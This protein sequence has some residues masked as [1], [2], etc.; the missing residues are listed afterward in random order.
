MLRKSVRDSQPAPHEPRDHSRREAHSQT[1]VTRRGRTLETLTWTDP[2]TFASPFSSWASSSPPLF[3]YEPGVPARR[4][5]FLSA[6]VRSVIFATSS[7]QRFFVFLTIVV[8]L[9]FYTHVCVI[10]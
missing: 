10:S 6:I 2:R 7:Q 1:L 8:V 3:V 9:W 4:R 5:A